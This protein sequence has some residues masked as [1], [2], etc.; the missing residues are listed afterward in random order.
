CLEALAS[1]DVKLGELIPPFRQLESSKQGPRVATLGQMVLENTDAS[2][3]PKSA[4]EIARI[5]LLA[6]PNN[7]TLRD[8]VS[9]LYKGVYAKTPGFAG[10]FDA[11]G[12]DAGRPVRNALRLLDLCLTLKPGDTLISRTEDTCV[13]VLEVDLVAGLFTIRRDGRARNLAAADIAREY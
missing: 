5:A 6:D 1:G 12:L 13:E 2:K 10:L 9:E 8:R 3:D 4:L 11:S 7:A